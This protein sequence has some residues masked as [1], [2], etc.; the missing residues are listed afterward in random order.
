[1]Q[2]NFVHA[3]NDATATL[4]RQQIHMHTPEAGGGRQAALLTT[5]VCG[6]GILLLSLDA[7]FD[8]G[9]NKLCNF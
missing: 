4:N 9:L 1:M 2:S 5:G 7:V 6:G 8:L 3:T